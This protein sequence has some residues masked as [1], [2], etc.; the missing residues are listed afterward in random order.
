MLGTGVLLLSGGREAEGLPW[1]TLNGKIETALAVQEETNE[2]AERSR[3][4]GTQAECASASS[5]QSQAGSGRSARG[6]LPAQP[7]RPSAKPAA[8]NGNAEPKAK[9]AP[10]STTAQA[11]SGATTAKSSA[12]ESPPGDAAPGEAG[13]IRLNSADAAALMEL[14]GIGAKKAQ[15]ILDYRAEHGPFRDVTELLEVK[16]IGAKMLEKMMPELA[17]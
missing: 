17:L 12:A 15:A 4:G 10:R 6:A 8:E 1:Q 11:A 14:P 9:T 5:G 3:S 13:K 2:A 16:G 7:S